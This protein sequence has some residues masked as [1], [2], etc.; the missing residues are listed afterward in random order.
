MNPKCLFFVLLAGLVGCLGGLVLPHFLGRRVL[1]V[2][3]LCFGALLLLEIIIP[4]YSFAMRPKNSKLWIHEKYSRQ[5]NVG[6]AFTVSEMT[7]SFADESFHGGLLRCYGAED[8]KEIIPEYTNSFADAKN[9]FWAYQ[10]DPAYIIWNQTRMD[11]YG[12]A[13][14]NKSI[15]FAVLPTVSISPSVEIEFHHFGGPK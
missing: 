5:S 3:A 15:Y 6:L 8:I 11:V 14:T 13:E 9:I 7:E 1:K 2:F 4:L 12:T 10:F